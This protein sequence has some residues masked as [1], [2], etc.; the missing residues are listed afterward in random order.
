MDEDTLQRITRGNPGALSI[1]NQ[2]TVEDI[3][4]LLKW[5]VFGSDLW[6][7]YKQCHKDVDELMEVARASVVKY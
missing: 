7:M 6:V 2:L 3:S 4:T 5:G 1:V